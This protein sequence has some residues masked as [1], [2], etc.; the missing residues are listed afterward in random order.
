[1]RKKAHDDVQ[2]LFLMKTFSKLG[3]KENILKI[4]RIY[5]NPSTNIIMKERRLLPLHQELGKDVITS[6][7]I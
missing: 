5:E 2:F 3:T 1:M 6:F 7:N 4:I